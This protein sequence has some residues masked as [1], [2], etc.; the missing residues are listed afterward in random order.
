MHNY[1]YLW[2]KADGPLSAR[3]VA[4]PFA[5]IFIRGVATTT[6]ERAPGRDQGAE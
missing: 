4:K 3:D 1:T 5:E 2:L 6:D